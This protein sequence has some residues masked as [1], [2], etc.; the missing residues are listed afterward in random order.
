MTRDDHCF[1]RIFMGCNRPGERSAQRQHPGVGRGLT[2]H[3]SRTR[4]AARLNSGVRPMTS[5]GFLT[6]NIALLVLASS[7][8]VAG[9]IAYFS[10]NS[11]IR[12]RVGIAGVITCSFWI[13]F[14]AGLFMWLFEGPALQQYSRRGHVYSFADDP[15]GYWL[16]FVALFFGTAIFLAGGILSI[17]VWYQNRTRNV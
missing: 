8:A 16:F 1:E 17:R 13:A 2:I 3:S 5:Q 6:A 7:C 10:P 15:T 11:W 14:S 12:H 9:V 4:S